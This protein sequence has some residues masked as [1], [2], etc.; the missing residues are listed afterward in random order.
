MQIYKEA[1]NELIKKDEKVYKEL[2]ESGK[3]TEEEYEGL[4][5]G[6]IT[7]GLGYND[8]AES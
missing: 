2:L 5:L 8:I 6:K 7:V 4:R 1:A 3:I